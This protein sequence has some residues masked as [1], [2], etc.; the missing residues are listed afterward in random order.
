MEDIGLRIQ[1]LREEKGYTQDQL[2]E[3]LFVSRQTISNYERNKSQPSLEMLE[4]IADIFDTDLASLLS[5]QT[6]GRRDRKRAVLRLILEGSI[7]LVLAT[8]Y[9][10]LYQIAMKKRNLYYDTRLQ[11]WICILLRPCLWAFAGYFLLSILTTVFHIRIPKKKWF[12][13]VDWMAAIWSMSYLVLMFPFP[14]QL[15]VSRNWLHLAYWVLGV[16]RNPVFS[17][18]YLVIPF[19]LGAAMRICRS[20][21]HLPKTK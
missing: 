8:A 16:T 14:L 9:H 21:Q 1:K 15:E 18:A 17:N 4:R 19:V 5:A 3:K 10:V 6:D 11:F 12:R 13:A 20:H 2:A 7:G